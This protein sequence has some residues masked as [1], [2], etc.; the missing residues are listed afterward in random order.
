MQHETLHDIFK[1]LLNPKDPAGTTTSA[2][3]R[4]QA[5]AMGAEDVECW[6]WYEWEWEFAVECVWALILLV[7]MA[8]VSFI[9]ES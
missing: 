2:A 7:S 6:W 5:A 3:G 9:V 8:L 1:S 4:P